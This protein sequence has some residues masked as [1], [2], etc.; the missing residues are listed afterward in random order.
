VTQFKRLSQLDD[1]VTSDSLV[2]ATIG[3]GPGELTG[4][5]IPQTAGHLVVV[6][7]WANNM[8]RVADPAAQ[9]TREVV[10][11]YHAHE[12]AHAWLMNKGGMAYLVRKK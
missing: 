8:V 2:L 10:R 4:A 6:C 7:G 3:Y 1:H 12:F 9:N 5:A 11:F